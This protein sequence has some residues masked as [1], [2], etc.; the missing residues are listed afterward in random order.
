MSC[1]CKCHISQC[2]EEMKH[3]ITCAFHFHVIR[4]FWCNSFID[5]CT[6]SDGRVS[7]RHHSCTQRDGR[8]RVEVG[9]LDKHEVDGSKDHDPITGLDWRAFR[10]KSFMNLLQRLASS[11]HI[12]NASTNFNQ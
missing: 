2:R 5:G 9:E 11:D 12:H 8:N 10:T 4:Y 1:I 7:H 6:P 3:T